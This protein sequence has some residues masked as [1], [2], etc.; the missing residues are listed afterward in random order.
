[1]GWRDI[2]ISS[3][4][5]V[6]KLL[7][8][9]PAQ[10][11]SQECCS[12]L[13]SLVFSPCSG[14]PGLGSPFRVLWWLIAYWLSPCPHDAAPLVSVSSAATTEWLFVSICPV[15]LEVLP[16]RLDP[17]VRSE[18]TAHLISFLFPKKSRAKLGQFNLPQALFFFWWFFKLL[19]IFF[20]DLFYM[21][22]S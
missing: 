6:F 9:L 17:G 13:V 11:H 8:S 12:F 19:N 18:A 15:H 22:F 10:E 5:L 1:M 14:P 7:L 21:W 20:T 4:S 16:A 2:A 3:V